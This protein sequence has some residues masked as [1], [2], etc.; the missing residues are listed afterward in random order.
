MIETISILTKEFMLNKKPIHDIFRSMGA[1]VYQNGSNLNIYN[2][3]RLYGIN[4]SY[5][6]VGFNE[7]NDG[8]L[9]IVLKLI[10]SEHSQADV[11]FT[12]NLNLISTQFI[13]N[14]TMPSKNETNVYINDRY[15]VK[16][17]CLLI[18]ILRSLNTNQ[19][20]NTNAAASNSFIN[21]MSRHFCNVESKLNG[22]EHKIML[23]KILTKSLQS[24]ENLFLSI[25]NLPD[26]QTNWLQTHFINFQLGDIL[27]I[28][29]VNFC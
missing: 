22:D 12:D 3:N 20:I 7:K 28:A 6:K 25:Q 2:L 8:L 17:V 10:E 19:S 1:L 23:C 26:Q 21:D 14:L 5:S 9:Y 15:K 29:K 11:E 27:A 13:F 4:E 24:L 18:K 16:S